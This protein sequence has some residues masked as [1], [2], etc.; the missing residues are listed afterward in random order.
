MKLED[1]ADIL[2]G[3]ARNPKV[4]VPYKLAVIRCI[5]TLRTPYERNAGAAAKGK[6]HGLAGKNG[7]DL[8]GDGERFKD[9]AAMT[10][11]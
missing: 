10:G 6:L 1:V 5:V 4:S 2:V 3:L 9:T 7:D 8:F 11:T